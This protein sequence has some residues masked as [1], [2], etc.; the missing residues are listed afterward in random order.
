MSIP[1]TA[2][3]EVKI[4]YA[5]SIEAITTANW[6][7][8]FEVRLYRDTT[9]ITTRTFIDSASS[10]GTHRFSISNTQVD[11]S[12]ATET[13]GYQLRIIFTT[14]TNVATGTA[15]NRNINAIVFP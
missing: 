12:V 4:D 10:A 11:T 9:L 5:V 8:S 3:I 1:V 15:L 2:G 7:M 13:A 6:A 14:A